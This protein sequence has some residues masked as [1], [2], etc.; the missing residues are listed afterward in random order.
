MKLIGWFLLMAGITIPGNL[1]AQEYGFKFGEFRLEELTKTKY[2]L[3]TTASAIVLEEYGHSYFESTGDFNLIGF[4]H[5]KIK[6]LRKEGLDQGNIEIG[7]YKGN[8][9]SERIRDISA[10]TY[11]LVDGKVQKSVWDFKNLIIEKKSQRWDIAKI[12][13]PEVRVGSVIEFMYDIESPYTF[14]FRTWHFQSEIPKLKSTYLADIPGN[15]RYNISLRGFFKLDVNT[16]EIIKDC[17]RPGSYNADCSRNLYEM[18]RIPAF[19]TEEYMTSEEN[20]I[21]QVRFELSEYLYFD[22]RKDQITK[23]WSDVDSELRKEPNFGGQLRRGKEILE[24]RPELLIADELAR[25]KAILS[26]IRSYY[27]WNGGY[28]FLSELGINKAFESKKGNVADINLSL[29]AALRTAGFK[30]DPVLLSTRANGFPTE[31]YPVLSDFNYVVAYL[32]IGDKKYFLDA[33]D[34]F[35]PFGLLPLSCLN[36]KGRVIGEEGSLWVDLKA[37]ERSKKV[38][39]MDLILDE[40][41]VAKGT[42]KTTYLGHEAATKRYSIFNDN[43][44]EG[45]IKKRKEKEPFTI[46]GFEFTGEN[47]VDKALVENLTVEFDLGSKLSGPTL[48]NPILTDRWTDNPFKSSTRLFPVDFGTSMEETLIISLTLPEGYKLAEVPSNVGLMLPNNGGKFILQTNVMGNKVTLS[49][50]FQINRPEYNSNEYH[51]LKELFGSIVQAHNRDLIIT[52]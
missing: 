2:D 38:V 48:F 23:S 50:S 43:G 41:G 17:W 22:G 6:I 7:L 4:R 33:V 16:S 32:T 35:M 34:D 27:S 42:I 15:Y 25:A 44:T 12:L 24:A 29:I 20:F 10:V 28:G 51:Y 3:D 49:S 36:H 9:R 5:V 21:S 52:K 13:L 8:T 19:K 40:S 45:H 30:A 18:T 46:I 39:M 14:N 11:N 37:S 31:I 1:I 26:Y 47:E